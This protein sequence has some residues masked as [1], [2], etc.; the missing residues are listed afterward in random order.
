MKTTLEE[1]D[2]AGMVRRSLTIYEGS[3][4]ETV[5]KSFDAASPDVR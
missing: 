1:I 2:S 3:R 5:D 4:I